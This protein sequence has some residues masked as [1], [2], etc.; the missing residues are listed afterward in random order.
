M[1][2][3]TLP[4]AIGKRWASAARYQLRAECLAEIRARRGTTLEED[5]QFLH[6]LVSAK[7][8]DKGVGGGT[9]DLEIKEQMVDSFSVCS[10]AGYRLDFNPS[11]RKRSSSSSVSMV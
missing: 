7:D 4:E 6:R 5:G 3:R 1:D 9:D 8:D 11:I 10:I 2:A